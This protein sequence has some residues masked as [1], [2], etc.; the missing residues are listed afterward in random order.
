MT[1]GLTEHTIEEKCVLE[2]MGALIKKRRREKRI[3]QDDLATRV[4]L[5]RTYIS[6]VERGV[7]NPSIICLL[8]ICNAL[9]LSLSQIGLQVQP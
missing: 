2:S 1:K 3:T 5:H 8:R 4:K 9:N 7:T 6:N